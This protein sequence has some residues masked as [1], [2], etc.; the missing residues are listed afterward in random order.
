MRN[1]SWM[2]SAIVCGM[3][4][5]TVA[6]A[7]MTSEQVQARLNTMKT[8]H[9]EVI[10]EGQGAKKQYKLQVEQ[11]ARQTI[12]MRTEQKMSM[13][14]DGVPAPAPATPGVVVTM[15]VVAEEVEKDGGFWY[16]ATV[17][18]ADAEE[19]PGVPPM[20]LEATR[21]ALAQMKGTVERGYM[22]ARGLTDM[23]KSKMDLPDDA[24]EDM[25]AMMDQLGSLSNSG[26][27]L[28]SSPIGIGAVWEMSNSMD[29]MG[30]TIDTLAR[31]TL[32]NVQ[33]DTINVSVTMYQIASNQTMENPQLPPNMT[34]LIE[35]MFGVTNG[36]ATVDLT[37]PMVLLS[38]A[39]G[40]T[41]MDIS[42]D[43]GVM[44][45][46]ISQRV[47]SGVFIKT[48]EEGRGADDVGATSY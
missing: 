45:Q 23:T 8:L 1:R 34:M 26:I 46:S 38:D 47:D 33:G 30:A 25:K 36:T 5:T 14:A 22:T 28:P 24:D 21:Q 3:S 27:P 7:Q 42:I 11:G 48:I 40:T 39:R 31:Y 2:L 20:V 13:T 37:R 4:L 19:T 18:K 44:K 41:N 16:T 9:V 17:T 15:N 32:L 10:D 6:S 43:M 35:R 29:I 12:E